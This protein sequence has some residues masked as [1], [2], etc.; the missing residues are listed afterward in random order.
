MKG[1]FNNDG[2]VDM[3]D[4][5]YMIK[6]ILHGNASYPINVSDGDFNSDGKI[7]LTDVVY[8][9]KHFLKID[10]YEKLGHSDIE[11]RIN[12]SYVEIK[13]DKQFNS[14]LIEFDNDFE[15]S[16]NQLHG[17][18]ITKGNRKVAG[19]SNKKNCILPRVGYTQF[20]K[21]EGNVKI[22]EFIANYDDQQLKVF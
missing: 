7:D 19:F 8:L 6:H 21:I 4:I 9:I 11:Y 15:C 5:I 18:Y 13:N 10:G 2:K 14:F 22:K 1:D 16:N 3:I 17:F 12:N 20:L